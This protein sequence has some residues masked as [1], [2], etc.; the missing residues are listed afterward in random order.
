LTNCG[1]AF[2]VKT[3]SGALHG[4][5]GRMSD[6]TRQKIKAIADELGYVTRFQID[7]G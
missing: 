2:S 4:G 6:E 7:A 5:S 3:V 1:P